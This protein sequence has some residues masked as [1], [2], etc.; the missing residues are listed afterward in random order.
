MYTDTDSLTYEIA[1]DDYIDL[2]HKLNY[3]KEYL[4]T[5]NYPRD[6]ILYNIKNHKR[7]GCFKDETGRIPIK[8]F[9]GLRSKMY[10]YIYEDNQNKLITNFKRDP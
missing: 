7:M 6:H 4:D 3:I 1:T 8:Q 5:S 10:S 2:Y 9:I